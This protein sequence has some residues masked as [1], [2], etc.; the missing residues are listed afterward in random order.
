MSSKL[1]A[2]RSTNRQRQVLHTIPKRQPLTPAETR[3]LLATRFDHGK[4]IS[5]KLQR[6]CSNCGYRSAVYWR[7][8]R[9][10]RNPLTFDRNRWRKDV[11]CAWC[12]WCLATTGAVPQTVR[13][14]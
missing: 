10:Q 2:S 7:L 13:V 9:R 5:G 14:S 8:V 3:R 12:A 4:V 6:T 1:S 11:L